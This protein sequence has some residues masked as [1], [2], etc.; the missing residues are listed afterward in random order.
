MEA[1][2]DGNIAETILTKEGGSIRTMQSLVRGE[3][4]LK[5]SLEIKAK[6][7]AEFFIMFCSIVFLIRHDTV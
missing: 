5:N 3:F 4:C 6:E 1:G 2:E 7:M